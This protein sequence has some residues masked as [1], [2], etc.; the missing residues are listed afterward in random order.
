MKYDR[1]FSIRRNSEWDNI[2]K[3][4]ERVAKFMTSEYGCKK[5]DAVLSVKDALR[6]NHAV[7]TG[8]KN[9]VLVESSLYHDTVY[10][11]CIV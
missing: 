5:E 4:Y 8:K 6:F 7:C 1:K 3:F 11:G 2:E 10:V 9:N